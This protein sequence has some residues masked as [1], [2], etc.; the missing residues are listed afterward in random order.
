MR[1]AER[2][3]RGLTSP[4]WLPEATARPRCRHAGRASHPV[5]P[6]TTPTAAPCEPGAAPGRPP[7]T[8]PVLVIIG[9]RSSPASPPSPAAPPARACDANPL[10]GFG[11]EASKDQHYVL[12]AAHTQRKG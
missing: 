6:T 9:S 2:F 3:E 1:L 7:R 8:G 5:R 4:I 12:D 10:A 11:S